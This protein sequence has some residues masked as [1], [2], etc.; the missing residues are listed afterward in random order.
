MKR[1]LRLLL[2]LALGG[3]GSIGA[4][5]A[6]DAPA[7]SGAKSE[8][9]RLNV[10]SKPWTGD[11]D[12]M[13]QRRVIRVAVPYS[14]TL[15]FN[16]KGRERGVAADHVRDFERYLNAKYAKQLGK[17][18]L[19]I[20]IVPT[21]RDELLSDVSG[22]LADIA[23]G[24][25]T[26][27]PEREKIVDFFAPAD[28]KPVSE[29]VVTSA[30]APPLTQAEDLSGRTVHVRKTSSYYASLLALNERLKAAGKPPAQLVIV[31]DALEDEDLME[32][33]NAGVI[34][35]IVVDDWKALA[36][37]AVLPNLRVDQGAVLRSGG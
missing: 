24:N 11:F 4:S 29:V 5:F 15:Y 7:A 27:T 28:Q 1:G 31:P 6:A 33:V 23:A 37:A 18:P 17:R 34:G 30:K 16:D 12:G 2:A 35:A 3:L 22:G 20:Y 14:R 9:R 25:L 19:T 36:W 10:E 8:A 13:L 32:M 21:T 26:V